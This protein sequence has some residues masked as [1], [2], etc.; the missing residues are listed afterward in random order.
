MKKII[1]ILFLCFLFTKTFSS[2]YNFN[3][4][5]Q[6]KYDFLNIN[7]NNLHLKFELNREDVIFI[8]ITNIVLTSCF[9]ATYNSTILKDNRKYII[10]VGADIVLC[11][12]AIIGSLKRK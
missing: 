5:E 11:G 7:T 10:F 2:N 6:F 3:T 12:T 8:V 4:Y 9:L 1:L